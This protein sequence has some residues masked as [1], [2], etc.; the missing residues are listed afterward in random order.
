MN[1]IGYF[2]IKWLQYATY[3]WNEYYTRFKKEMNT[4]RLKILEENFK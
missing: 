4:I 1:T 2:V 3:Q